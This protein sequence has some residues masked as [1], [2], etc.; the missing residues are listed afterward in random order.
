MKYKEGDECRVISNT[1][2]NHALEINTNVIVDEAKDCGTVGEYYVA[3]MADG[4]RFNILAADLGE[5]YFRIN[6]SNVE[7]E[8]RYRDYVQSLHNGKDDNPYDDGQ[9]DMLTDPEEEV[10]E[11][12]DELQTNM[13]FHDEAP[14]LRL[15]KE[16]KKHKDWS[17]KEEWETSDRGAAQEPYA[18]FISRKLSELNKEDI[19]KSSIE[20]LQEMRTAQYR[21][22][23]D[24]IYG[25]PKEE[26]W[27][28]QD[29]FEEPSANKKVSS[30][31]G[32]SNYYDFPP[33]WNTLNDV[34]ETKSKYQWKEHSFHLGNIM[35]A[36][37]RWGD[38]DGT[39]TPYDAKKV[40]YSAC[41]VLKVLVGPN[42]LRSYLGA[43]LDDPQF[44]YESKYKEE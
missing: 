10:E 28:V 23:L 33:E 38:K 11:I 19:A 40:I 30:D 25:P 44:R 41:R 17:S 14:H 4:V 31:G 29:M 9:Y 18:A 36:V 1:N 27:E 7:R 16:C 43:L 20:E 2:T 12:F 15:R 26:D 21:A 32:P 3:H 22:F 8:A 24:S 6:K 35:K 34:I 5:T 13:E 39:T 42:E 37:V